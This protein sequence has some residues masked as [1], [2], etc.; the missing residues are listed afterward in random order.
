MVQ[1]KV[2]SSNA[3]DKAFLTFI[4]QHT[5]II[6]HAIWRVCGTTYPALQADVEQEVH[7][8]LWERWRADQGIDYPVSYLYTVALRTALALVRTH[9]AAVPFD[10]VDPGALA[11]QT[12]PAD[13]TLTTERALL[14]RAYLD[15]LSEEQARAVRAYL[16]GFTQ[17]EI[18]RLYGWSAAVVRHRIY[19]GIQ[20]LR[21]FVIQ[22]VG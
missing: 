11:C 17:R 6:R 4:Q 5:R 8:A 2:P 7:L 13:E 15:Q 10:E 20:A 1:V 18:A 21:S 12:A 14:L 16:A 19:R 3:Q 22:E 9:A